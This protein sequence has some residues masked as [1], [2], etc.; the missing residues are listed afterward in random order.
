MAHLTQAQI[1]AYAAAAGAPDPQLAAA[2]AMPESGGNTTAH[3]PLPPDDSYGLW[4]INMRGELGPQRRKALGITSNVQL[5]DPATNA[6]AMMLVSHGG[7]DFTPW[8][9]FTSGE[10]KH[11]VGGAQQA[12]WGG[13]VWNGLKG[14]VDPLGPFLG[15]L[16]P[17]NLLP[18]GG[19]PADAIS[20]VGEV[21]G[22]IGKAGSWL[23]KASNWVR[24]GYVVGGGAL[25][26]V[27]LGMVA[28]DAELNAAA[29][30]VQK[31]AKKAGVVGKQTAAG[32][33]KAAGKAREVGKKATGR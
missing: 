8:S 27:G 4:Q 6:R 21:V 25:V 19:G 20:A 26:I 23:S 3:N 24:I 17:W 31:V 13:D 30:T 11:Y 1:A 7:T 2:V 9:G 22:W 16:D 32:T 15:P 10:Y 29:G 5:Y 18:G 33:K 14:G 28:K 12:G